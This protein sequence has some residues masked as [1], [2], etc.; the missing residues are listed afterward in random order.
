MTAEL[1]D[2]LDSALVVVRL[3]APNEDPKRAAGVQ[4][5]DA[6]LEAYAKAN[7]V[8]SPEEV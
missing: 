8:G 6:A 5:L 2:V 7:P 4:R 3:H 1:Q